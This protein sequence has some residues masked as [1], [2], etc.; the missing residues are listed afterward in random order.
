MIG[1]DVGFLTHSLKFRF[2]KTA[3][4]LRIIESLAPFTYVC[5]LLMFSQENY[6]FNDL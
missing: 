1:F 3:A 5:R 4:K 6:V 2:L